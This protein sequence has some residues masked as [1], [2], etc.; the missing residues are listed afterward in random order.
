MPNRKKM[1]VRG[2]TR[3][4]QLGWKAINILL[5]PEQ[6][7]KLKLG[8]K[9]RGCSVTTYIRQSLQDALLFDCVPS[10]SSP[11]KKKGK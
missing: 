2:G 11:S 9:F 1:E 10:P 8:A 5:C 7:E 4:R 3:M 6:F